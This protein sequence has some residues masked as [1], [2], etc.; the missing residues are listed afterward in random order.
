MNSKKPQFQQVN[1][2]EIDEDHD[3]QRL[4]NFLF[5]YLADIPRTK[6]YRIIRKGEVRVN[7]KR[8]KPDLRI[9][10]GDQIR[11]PPLIKSAT[12]EVTDPPYRLVELIADSV[13]FE[14][15]H[16]L[17]INKPESIA[18]HPGSGLSF[19]IIDLVRRARKDTRIELVHRLDRG[20]SG[21]LMLAKSRK[22]LLHFQSLFKQHAMFFSESTYKHSQ[23]PFVNDA[24]SIGVALK[25]TAMQSVENIKPL[26]ALKDDDDSSDSDNDSVVLAD[27]LDAPSTITFRR[28]TLKE[29]DKTSI[30]FLDSKTSSSLKRDCARWPDSFLHSFATMVNGLSD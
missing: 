8:A 27:L 19:G 15:Q 10:T 17:V 24:A 28:G 25:S 16:L 22:S 21:C 13:V 18:V 29:P 26:T 6:V 7:K 3:G 14:N 1:F 11:I 30:A 9:A 4:D 23:Q 5:K 2:V 12:G 20:T